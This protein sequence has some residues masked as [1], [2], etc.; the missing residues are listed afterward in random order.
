MKTFLSISHIYYNTL[1]RWIFADSI[2]MY[3]AIMLSSGSITCLVHRQ[4][5]TCYYLDRCVSR[6]LFIKTNVARVSDSTID[7]LT[8]DVCHPVSLREAVYE[9]ICNIPKNNSIRHIVYSQQLKTTLML[10]NVKDLT[11]LKISYSQLIK[12]CYL[13][14]LIKPN[15][16]I[17]YDVIT[18]FILYWKSGHVVIF[19][20]CLMKIN[21]YFFLEIIYKKS[22]ENRH[23]I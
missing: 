21:L 17:Q 12:R 5:F 16:T 23:V 8:N 20:S 6:R 19:F 15:R 13:S 10:V 4:L 9:K 18:I 11:R 22:I 1:N 14:R 2:S 7:Q 3:T